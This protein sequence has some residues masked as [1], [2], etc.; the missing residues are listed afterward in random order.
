MFADF[1]LLQL[2]FSSVTAS[3]RDWE[4]DCFDFLNSVHPESE[5]INPQ[6]SFDWNCQRYKIHHHNWQMYPP[7]YQINILIL[8]ICCETIYKYTHF[9]AKL[10]K[11]SKCVDVQE[12]HIWRM[13]LCWSF[14]T[15]SSEKHHH[16][17]PFILDLHTNYTNGQIL[18]RTWSNYTNCL[19]HVD[20]SFRDTVNKV[21]NCDCDY[22]IEK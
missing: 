20:R 7:K 16:F 19:D 11:R 3:H 14:Y 21:N 9:L 4:M 2:L 10:F 13:G 8:L 12:L 15:L 6:K 17:S 5:N 1:L 18:V 22:E